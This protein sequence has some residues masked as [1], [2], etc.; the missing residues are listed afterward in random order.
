MKMLINNA[1]IVTRDAVLEGGSLVVDGGIITAIYPRSLEN[2]SVKNNNSHVLSDFDEVL[3]AEGAWLVPGFVDIHCHGGSGCEFMDGTR[4]SVE[5]VERYHLQHGT[6]TL[7]ATTLSSSDEERDHALDALGEYINTVQDTTIVGAH[8][9]GPWLNPS[10]CGA[11]N[12][13]Y[14]RPSYNGEIQELKARYPFILRVSAAP[15][16]ENGL[17]IAEGATGLSILASIAHTDA[18]F[19]EIERASRHGY[20]LMTHFYSGMNGVVRKNS[21]RIAGAVEAG[22]HLDDMYVELIADGKHLPYE[23][24]R[25]VYKIKGAD[26]ICLV[27][28]AI[29]A[30]GMS[31]GVITRIGTKASGLD[32]IVEDGVAKLLNRQSFAGSTATMDRIF[33]TMMKATGADMVSL[34][35]MASLNP[36]QLLGLL[37]R[38]EIAVGKLA[39][40]VLLDNNINIKAVIKSGVI[41]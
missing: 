18:D 39:D 31:D 1:N 24:L 38:G 33:R 26:R 32:V 36:A 12:P 11:Q 28:D 5:S 2:D 20:R 16:I 40:L 14:I 25:F 13:E 15:E 4:E 22:L 27:T 23:L 8:L 10:Q 34:S 17:A 9:E 3:D 7:L 41:V 37:D 35:R 30:S 19:S 29:R 6:T 21:Y